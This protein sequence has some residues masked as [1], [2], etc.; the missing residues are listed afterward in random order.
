MAVSKRKQSSSA[1]RP[2]L[3][4]PRPRRRRKVLRHRRSLRRKGNLL[5]GLYRDTQIE[6][7]K[8]VFAVARFFVGLA[9]QRRRMDRRDYF[10]RQFGRQDL[11]TLAR[12]TK[13]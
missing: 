7:E 4:K 13:L 8:L 2:T 12:D 10:R 11:P 3:K 9:E 5:R 1:P 6:H